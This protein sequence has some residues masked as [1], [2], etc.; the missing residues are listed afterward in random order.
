MPFRHLP[1][2]CNGFVLKFSNSYLFEV[3]Y[4]WTILGVVLNKLRKFCDSYSPT[5]RPDGIQRTTHLLISV[6]SYEPAPWNKRLSV[7]YIFHG[8]I[9]IPRDNTFAICWLKIIWVFCCSQF[10]T[11]NSHI[12]KFETVIWP[13]WLLSGRC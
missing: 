9:N 7:L 2:K 11:K 8:I 10:P 6:Q 13:R 3:Q 1:C 5:L 4:W 12:I